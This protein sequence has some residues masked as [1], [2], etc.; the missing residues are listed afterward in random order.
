MLAVFWLPHVGAEVFKRNV[1][2]TVEPLIG[3]D[4]PMSLPTVMAMSF[5]Q[6]VPLPHDL[7]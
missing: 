6:K 2:G 7:T 1:L 3:E 4:T 5:S